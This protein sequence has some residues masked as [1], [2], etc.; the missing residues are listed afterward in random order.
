[1]S[2]R[3]A[4][5]S[6]HAAIH[7]LLAANGLP[8]QDLA[9]AD[10]AFLIADGGGELAG[11]VGI[12]RF[13]DTGLLRSLAVRAD[14]RRT[15]TGGRLVAAAESAARAQGLHEL[16]LLTQ[17]AS[18]FFAQRGYR[19]IDRASA[20]TGVQDSAEFRSLC[21]ASADCLIKPLE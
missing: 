6:E 9:G 19:A 12:Q 5:E 21:P 7:A 13:G 2:I 11:V 4:L 17:T 10:I 3:P 16:V 1:M 14:A 15:G 8:V 18:A 20:P